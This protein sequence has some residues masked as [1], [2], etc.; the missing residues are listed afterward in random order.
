MI[1]DNLGER[2]GEGAGGGGGGGGGVEN[3]EFWIQ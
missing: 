1:G 2:G 3:N